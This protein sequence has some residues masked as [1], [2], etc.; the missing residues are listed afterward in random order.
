MF[1]EGY[2]DDDA[3]LPR[4]HQL[5]RK[6]KELKAKGMISQ[7]ESTHLRLY[8]NELE[9]IRAKCHHVW[10]VILMFTGHRRFCRVCDHE[11]R[12]YRHPKD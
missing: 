12:S 7:Q 8:E 9:A 10:Q 6:I 3:L 2:D 1:W 4:A 11:D 5:I